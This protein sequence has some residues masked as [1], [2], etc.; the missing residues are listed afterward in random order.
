MRSAAATPLRLMVITTVPETLAVF[1]PSQLRSLAQEGFEVHAVSSPGLDLAEIGK[2][3]G[4]T[5]HAIPMERK[6]HPAHDL[7]S[8]FRL[9]ALMRKLRPHIVHAHTPKAG[10]LGMA[11][12]RATCVPVRLYTVHGLPLLTRTGKWRKVLEAAERASAALASRTYSVSASVRELV[13]DLKLCPASKIDLLGDGSCA[14]VNLTR[15]NPATLRSSGSAFREKLGIPSGALLLSFVG[16]VARDKGIEVLAEAWPVI[17]HQFPNI[18]L[19][20][21]GPLDHTDPVSEAALT[22]LRTHARVHMLGAQ[23]PEATASIY[24]ATDIFVL[25]TFREGLSQVALEAGAMGVPIVSC[26]VSGLDAV[27]DG[28]TGLLVPPRDPISL[29]QAIAKLAANPKFRETVG[30]AAMSHIQ[31]RYSEQRVNQLW[32][33]EYRKLVKESLSNVAAMESRMESHT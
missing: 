28:V 12:A 11:A 32:M 29:A 19:L 9:F 17:A 4:V 8:L 5:V 21:A 15:F 24:S 14:G 26:R 20:L 7:V 6:P 27:Q 1:F 18:H 13:V 23:A 10:L 3:P 16:R 25:P 30:R 31:A 22:G 2:I 33:D